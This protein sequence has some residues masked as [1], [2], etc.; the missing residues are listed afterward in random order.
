MP[1]PTGPNPATL[2]PIEGYDRLCFL[3]NIVTNPNII[4]GDYT[5]YDDFED[6]L[7]FEKN[8]RYHFD[9]IGDKLRVG[10]FCAIAP[11]VEFILNGGNEIQ[12]A[13]H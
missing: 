4:V 12:L 1:I 13:Q 5:C 8:V 2:Y 9:F 6:V 7:N 10:K 3:K 11:G